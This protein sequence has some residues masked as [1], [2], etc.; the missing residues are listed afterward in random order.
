MLKVEEQMEL[1]VLKKHGESIRSLTRSTGRSRNTV[2]RYVRGGEAAATRMP[3][4]KRIEKPFGEHRLLAVIQ[5]AITVSGRQQIDREELAAIAARV[6]A[7]SERQRQV[8]QLAVQGYSNKEIAISLGISPRTV[9]TYRA[10]VM[11]RTG[12]ATLADLVRMAM[13]LEADRK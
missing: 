11:Q 12:A 7:L 13:R 9:E 3:A 6:D 2:R 1:V 4:P 8:M 10:W 5:E